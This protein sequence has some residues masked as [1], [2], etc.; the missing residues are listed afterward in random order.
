MIAVLAQRDLLG[1]RA[2][3]DSKGPSDHKGRQDHPAQQALK[4]TQDCKVRLVP[5]GY[6]ASLVLLVLLVPLGQLAPKAIPAE[7]AN[8]AQLECEVKRGRRGLLVTRIC[9]RSM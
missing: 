3:P 9:A 6:G 8:P 1:R 7:W 5:K 4:E 2:V